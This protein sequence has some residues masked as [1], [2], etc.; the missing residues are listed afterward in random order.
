MKSSDF[1]TSEYL[2]YLKPI[3]V[4]FKAEVIV[5]EGVRFKLPLGKWTDESKNKT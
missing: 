2:E 5:I 1:F 4:M 3:V